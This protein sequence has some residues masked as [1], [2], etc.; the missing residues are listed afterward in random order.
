MIKKDVII[1]DVGI[2]KVNEKIYGD[3]NFDEVYKKVK[4]IT[5]VPGGVGVMTVT[6][7]I[8]NVLDC[9]KLID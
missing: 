5:P 7:V 6:S 4:L 9:Y 8:S 2:T 1:I 3:V